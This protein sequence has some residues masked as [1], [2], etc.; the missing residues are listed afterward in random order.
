MKLSQ[1]E[2]M[3]YTNDDYRLNVLGMTRAFDLI[4]EPTAEE[5]L[6][7]MKNE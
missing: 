6:E 2:L 1:H 7:E 3:I 5:I 4:Q